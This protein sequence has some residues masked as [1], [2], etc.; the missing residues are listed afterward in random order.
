MMSRIRG[1]EGGPDITCPRQPAAR[2]RDF[3]DRVR[4]SEA[5][6]KGGSAQGEERMSGRN[7]RHDLR[8]LA[9]CRHR[10]SATE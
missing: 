1:G 10:P 9:Y 8:K 6:Y 7:S 5:T 3:I 4:S 2:A